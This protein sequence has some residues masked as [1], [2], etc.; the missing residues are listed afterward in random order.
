[1]IGGSAT[2]ASM[3]GCMVAEPDSRPAALKGIPALQPP[4]DVGVPLAVGREIVRVAAAR[5]P[6]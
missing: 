6:R 5:H 1:M 2:S 4:P 3:Y